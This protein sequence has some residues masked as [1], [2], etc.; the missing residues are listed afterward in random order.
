[1]NIENKNLNMFVDSGS[2]YTLF[3]IG[4]FVRNFPDVKLLQ[5]RKNIETMNGQ[6][7]CITRT[8]NL[9]ITWGVDITRAMTSTSVNDHVAND[10][11]SRFKGLDVLCNTN[12]W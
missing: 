2:C 4:E 11:P 3:P 12:H 6:T 5:C 9:F 8:A 10:V 1:M 7:M